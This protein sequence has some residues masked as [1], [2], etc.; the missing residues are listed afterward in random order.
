MGRNKDKGIR[1]KLGGRNY[2]SDM[3]DGIVGMRKGG[4]RFIIAPSDSGRQAYDIEVTKVKNVDQER[5]VPVVDSANGIVE[6]MAKVGQPVITNNR[7]RTS[8]GQ[9]MPELEDIPP[10]SVSAFS[11]PRSVRRGSQSHDQRT[12]N[13]PIPIIRAESPSS[14][15]SGH[16]S[17]R[18]VSQHSNMG[19]FN[20]MM[21]ET[22]L[23]NTEMRMNIQRISDKMD[24]M[25]SHQTSN[26]NSV[27]QLDNSSDIM[28]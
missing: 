16:S 23:Q 2:F 24:S 25:L 28:G 3:E 14:V 18:V 8:S 26:S 6:R 1:F 11:T 9:D 27:R 17:S 21:S 7:V 13:T 12:G 19:E 22:R 5:R 10:R 20:M 15:R 4:R